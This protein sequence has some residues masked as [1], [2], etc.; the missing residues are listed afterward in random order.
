MLDL[1]KLLLN[2]AAQLPRYTSYPPANHFNSNDLG[3]L[4]S[5]LQ[6]A[7]ASADSLSLYLHIPFC[8]R[9]CWFC[10]C[11]TKHTLSYT[12]VANYVDVLVKEIARY[13]QQGARSTRVTKIH[14][15][16]GSPSLLK[17]P[18]LDKIR[19]AL[20]RAFL[21]DEKTEISVELD[22]SDLGADSIMNLIEFGLTRAS[23][24]VQDFDPE[25]QVAINRPQSFELTSS[26]V[27]QLRAAGVKSINIDALYGLPGQT[28]EKLVATVEKLLSLNPDRISLFGY[29]HVPWVKPHQKMIDEKTLPGQAQRL[30]DASLASSMIRSAGYDAIGIDHFAKPDDNLAKAARNGK[31]KRNFQGYTDD[32]SQ[33]L[34]GFGP[35][36]ISGFPG[37]FAQN[38]VATG[39]YTAAITGGLSPVARGLLLLQ[40]DKLNGW[41]IERLMCDFSFSKAELEQ[42]FGEEGQK[43]WTKAKSLAEMSS[44]NLCRITEGRFEMIEEAR[45]LVRLVASKFD[46]WLQ[47][48]AFQYSKAV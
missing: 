31:L 32:D 22:P 28:S 9:L 21:I 1:E 40:E 3:A 47:A 43:A 48:S 14:L 5:A 4:N 8:D 24:G 33:V 44:A 27:G 15:G 19:H 10:G 34:L 30:H 20:N 41:I 29:A 17:K 13:Q 12:P 18:E 16:G 45:P 35:S 36:S 7:V 25:I 38:Q 23:I 26:V 2:E 6:S 46:T 42:H 37:G 39:L 11:H